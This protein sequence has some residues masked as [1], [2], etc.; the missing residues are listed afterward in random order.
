MT[1]IDP[2]AIRKLCEEA[3]AGPWKADYTVIHGCQIHVVSYRDGDESRVLATLDMPFAETAEFL[4]A[5]RSL[6]PALLDECERLRSERDIA[7]SSCQQNSALLFQ[8]ATDRDTWKARAE[9]CE[10]D[11]HAL[12][13]RKDDVMRIATERATA[14]AI[15]AWLDE[16]GSDYY[17]E[18]AD[19]IRDE[20]CKEQP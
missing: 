15:A 4:A 7:T 13:N 12:R 2:A 18:A 11:F 20:W 17:S 8:A 3:Q 10:S 14:E 5:S 1:P 9:Q 16:Q 19:E 6:V